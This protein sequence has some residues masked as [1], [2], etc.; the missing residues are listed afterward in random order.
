MIHFAM[1][2][3]SILITGGTG[4][5]GWNLIDRLSQQ[6]NIVGTFHHT[7]PDASQAAD[8][9][10]ISLEAEDCEKILTP[11][12]PS[13][14]IHCAAVSSIAACA[15]DEKRAHAVNVDATRRLAE[16]ARRENIVFIF[17]STDLVFDGVKG[18][19]RE[20]DPVHPA[21]YYAET[22]C[23]AEESVQAV[24]GRYYLLRTA[25]MYGRHGTE[26]GSFLRWTVD[27]LRKNQQLTLYKNQIRNPLFVPDTAGVVLRLLEREPAA[28]I[29]HLG[30]PGRYSRPEIGAAIAEA[31]GYS[32]RNIVE[33]EFLRAPELM[34][35]DD[36][37][38]VT[39]KVQ[40]ATGI[41]FTSLRTGLASIAAVCQQSE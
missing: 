6:Y 35:M 24:G 18:G 36:T 33:T 23:L 27:A 34:P 28:G 32:G 12:Q 31:F 29:Y 16:Y 17:I 1:D 10:R 7:R 26:P 8:W 38:L 20:E 19:Y 11:Y 30:G 2:A 25:L 3:T 13:A 15:A 41:S 39:D 22:K 21:S 9:I 4:F 5:L 37:T 14:I 40:A